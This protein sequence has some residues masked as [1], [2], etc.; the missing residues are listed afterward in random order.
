M[1]TLA[2]T[3]QYDG[4]VTIAVGPS[5]MSKQ[6]QNRELLW[7][8]L[9]K[10]LGIPERT[11]ET[12]DE[13]AHMKKQRRDEIKDVGGFVGGTLKGGR[14]KASAI[15]DRRLLTL[16]L[17]SI[18]QGQDP[19]DTVSLIIG[20]A[21]VCYSTHSHTPEKPRLRIV[22]PLSRSV[23]PAASS[24]SQRPALPG[25]GFT[26]SAVP[27]PGKSSAAASA[28]ISGDWSTPIIS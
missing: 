1:T 28:S 26:K 9:V 4:A 14:R 5:R 11:Q 21:A 6:W 25:T 16:D 24:R 13:Y 12:Q 8:E 3:I 27:P 7:S 22:I 17:D 15:I 2:P 10:R 19:W 18:P 23:A 20:C